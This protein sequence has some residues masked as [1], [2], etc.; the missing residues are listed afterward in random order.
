[1]KAA[2]DKFGKVT[3]VVSILSFFDTM[4]LFCDLN[5]ATLSLVSGLIVATK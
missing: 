2:A 4:I 3:M 5:Q 1:M